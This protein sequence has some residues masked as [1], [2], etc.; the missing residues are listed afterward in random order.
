MIK[1]QKN[2]KKT[3]WINIIKNNKFIMAKKTTMNLVKMKKIL[4]KKN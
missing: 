1:L 2:I 3:N 4:G